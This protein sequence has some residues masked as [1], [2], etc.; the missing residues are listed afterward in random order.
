M[1]RTPATVHSLGA[2]WKKK[3]EE[4]GKQKPTP[5]PAYNKAEKYE[6]H[7]RRPTANILICDYF[8]ETQVVLA[9]THVTDNLAHSNKSERPGIIQYLSYR[10]SFP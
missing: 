8:L 1:A 2:V 6:F 10:T 9:P 4:K 5:S 7:C 3:K